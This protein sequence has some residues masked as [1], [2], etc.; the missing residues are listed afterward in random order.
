MCVLTYLFERKVS[1]K[2]AITTEI[3]NTYTPRSREDE[4]RNGHR[5]T[6]RNPRLSKFRFLFKWALWKESYDDHRGVRWAFR[7]PF[8]VASSRERAVYMYVS[9]YIC[10]L[11]CLFERKVNSNICTYMCVY[12]YTCMYIHIQRYEIHEYIYAC[13]YMCVNIYICMFACVCV[14]VRENVFL[15]RHLEGKCLLCVYVCMFVCVGESDHIWQVNRE[16][17]YERV[18]LRVCLCVW[19]RVCSLTNI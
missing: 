18:C 17:L 13:T 10:V 14:C 16:Y 3:C 7:W 6:K 15:Y 12:V 5:N 1:N 2:A 9:T 8:R 19:E 11:T 4:T